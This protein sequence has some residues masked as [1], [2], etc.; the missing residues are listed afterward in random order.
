MNKYDRM[1]KTP[2]PK[3][4]LSLGIPTTITMLI[5]NIYNLADTYFVSQLGTSASGAVGVVFGLMA[6]LQAIGFMLGQGAGSN[7]SR[8]L[9]AKKIDDATVFASTSYFSALFLGTLMGIIGLLM[10]DPFMR[11]LG[12]TE[13]IL[14]YSRVYGRFILLA[15]PAMLSSCVLNNILRFE[16]RAMLGMIGMASGAILNIGGDM[17]FMNKFHMGITGAGLSTAISQYISAGILLSIFLLRR[18]QTRLSIRYFTKDWN[19]VW[20]I[21]STGFPSMIRQGLGSISTMILNH[22]CAYFYGDEAVAAMSIVSRCA[23]FLFCVGLGI[24]QGFQPVCGFNYGAGK[25]SRVRKGLYFTLCAG[26]VTLGM[27]SL[28]GL[29]QSKWVIERFSDDPV[30]ISI[31]IYALRAKCLALFVVPLSVCGNMLFQSIG[32]SGRAS[33]LSLLKDGLFFIPFISILP[34]LF[35]IRGIQLAQ[36]MADVLSSVVTIPFVAVFLKKLPKDS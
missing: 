29:F 33:F 11:V 2:L 26:T 13:T 24:G 32:K 22:Q 4:I 27:F 35:G 20:N 14:P 36:P 17:L 8:R 5:T 18:T 31:A 12:S 28:F 16:G 9:G 21:V 7:I 10:L 19:V 15:A 3:L 34:C 25:Y 6:V 30:V 1:T 23:M